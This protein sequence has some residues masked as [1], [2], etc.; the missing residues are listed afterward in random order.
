MR[1]ID[2]GMNEVITRRLIMEA[3]KDISDRAVT[4]QVTFRGYKTVETSE[5]E[6]EFEEF[7]ER[8]KEKLQLQEFP[9][10]K[11]EAEVLKRP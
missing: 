4:L 8:V 6:R 9:K 3:G 5:I 11:V 7:W 10:D 1:R 2:K